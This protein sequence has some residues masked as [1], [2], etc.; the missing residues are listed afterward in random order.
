MKKI[1]LTLVIFATAT[2]A[3]AQTAPI[4]RTLSTLTVAEVSKQNGTLEIIKS[5]SAKTEIVVN[6]STV[7]L[8]DS[9]GQTTTYRILTNYSGEVFEETRTAMLVIDDKSNKFW[10]IEYYT[11]G[12]NPN[13]I[14]VSIS[15]MEMFFQYTGTK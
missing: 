6:D 11:N 1:V 13:L 7:T 14:T 2:I 5:I 10:E 9:V 3:G 15:N 12:E 4:K 8:L